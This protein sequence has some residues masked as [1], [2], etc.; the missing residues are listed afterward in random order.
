VLLAGRRERLV[1]ALQDPLRPDVDPASGGHLAE[2]RQ[3]LRLEA[4]ELVPGRPP[5]HEQGVRDEHTRRPLAR[6]EDGD[7]LAALDEKRLVVAQSKEGADDV[8]QRLMAPRGAARP[9][10]DDESLGMLRDLRV[11]VVQEHP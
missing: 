9:A 4:T 2:H 5:R 3:P 1:R 6:P 8:A 7:R 11:E 10:V